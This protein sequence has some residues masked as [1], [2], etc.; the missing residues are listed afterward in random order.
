MKG[1]D[2]MLSGITNKWLEDEENS[3]KFNKYIRNIVERGLL[4]EKKELYDA[5]YT[6]N[7]KIIKTEYKKLKVYLLNK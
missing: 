5:I 1:Y 2:T 3:I 7:G 4:E 6:E